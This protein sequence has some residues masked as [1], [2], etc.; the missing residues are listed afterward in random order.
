MTDRD[1]NELATWESALK[2]R[3]PLWGHRNWIVVADSA[4]PAQSNPG[5]ET[6]TTGVDHM[7]L[8]K[9]TLDALTNCKHVKPNIYLDSE[10]KFVTEQDAPGITR[11][12]E[13]LVRLLGGRDRTVIPHEQIITKLDDSAQLFRILILKSTMTIPYSSVF[14]ELDCGYWNS[15]AE[16]RLREAMTRT[17]SRDDEQEELTKTF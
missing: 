1:S 10:F 2:R 4:Y 9:V 6:I 16:G 7:Y 8:L 3:L 11:F 14:L 17:R 15:Q 12:R 13:S 5:I